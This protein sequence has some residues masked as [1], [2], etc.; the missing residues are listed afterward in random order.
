MASS[1]PFVAGAGSGGAGDISPDQGRPSSG[2]LSVPGTSTSGGVSDVPVTPHEQEAPVNTGGLQD[3]APSQDATNLGGPQAISHTASLSDQAASQSQITNIQQN[4]IV[5]TG[6]VSTSGYRTRSSTQSL[7]AANTRYTPLPAATKTDPAVKRG[8]G[9][10]QNHPSQAAPQAP[11][12]NT[13][14]TSGQAYPTLSATNTT[15]IQAPVPPSSSASSITSTVAPYPQAAPLPAL[16]PYVQSSAPAASTPVQDPVSSQTITQVQLA[17]L[18]ELLAIYYARLPTFSTFPSGQPYPYP[19]P[20]VVIGPLADRYPYTSSLGSDTMGTQPQYPPYGNPPFPLN[21]YLGRDLN[22]GPGFPS[23]AV[24]GGPSMA[25]FQRSAADA[26]VDVGFGPGIEIAD[27]F[28]ALAERSALTPSTTKALIDAGYKI[29]VERSPQRIFDDM[30]YEEVGAT[31]VPENTWRDAPEDNIIIGLKELPVETFPLKHVHVQ[32]AHCYKQQA[33]W[34]KVLARFARGNGVLLD[35]EFLT[36]SNGRRVAAFGYH[37]G[38]AGAWQ[39]NH[40]D[41]P[42]P[43]VSSYPNEDDLIADV[44]KAIAQGTE[45]TGKAP[46][47]LI[48]GALGR[49]GSGAVDLCS[50]AGVPTENI[51]RWDMAETAKGGPFPEIVESDIFIN[52]IYLTSKIPNFVDLP[53]LDTPNRKLSVV[54]DVS[55]DTTNPNN[56]IPIYTVATTFDKPT[57]P[58][59]V[60]GEPPLSVISIDHLPSLLPREASEAFSNDLL[61]H[62]LRLKDWRSDPVWARAE[63]LFREKVSTLPESEL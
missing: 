30:E 6:L 61:P 36:D 52:C 58:V 39:I 49:C 22:N 23:M 50:R 47:V 8:R 24:T 59:E 1:S 54:C 3:Q 29:N 21:A 57:V 32:F 12:P 2:E 5:P 48:I 43:S 11:P 14:A 20:R 16:P 28:K 62:L 51:L 63:K 33:G 38:F 25:C 44:K 42:L 55:A 18:N 31:L 15:A 27:E 56:P 7:P 40:K 45:K 10:A 4:S 53:S 26:R 41:Q 60:K 37:A 17:L 35:L 9:R 19:A 34:E 13:A 46:K